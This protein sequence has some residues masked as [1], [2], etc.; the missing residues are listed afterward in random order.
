MKDRGLHT[1]VDFFK[2]I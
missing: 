2:G 1:F